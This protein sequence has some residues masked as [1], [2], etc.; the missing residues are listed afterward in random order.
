MNQFT[1]L[2]GL[3]LVMAGMTIPAATGSFD[4]DT[5]RYVYAAGAVLTLL[6]RLFAQPYRGDNL[7]LRR[8][9]RLQSWSAIFY[10]VAAFF[11][12]YDRTSLRDWIV[13]TLAGAVVQ[14]VCNVM[15]SLQ[16][17]KKRRNS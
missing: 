2:L 14:I 7:R 15:I 10:C 5:F 3:V 4:N 8:L 11:C 6:G 13:F 1:I 12:F 16:T 17:R 9:I